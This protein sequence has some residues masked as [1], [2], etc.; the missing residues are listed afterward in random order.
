MID[1]KRDEYLSC[2]TQEYYSD[3]KKQKTFFGMGFDKN[4]V[5][6]DVAGLYLLGVLHGDM[7]F[8]LIVVS[9]LLTIFI[10]SFS[11]FL[12]RSSIF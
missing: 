9:P 1:E 7:S 3:M 10:S 8:L 11:N 12:V 4:G 6:I 5:P 2:L